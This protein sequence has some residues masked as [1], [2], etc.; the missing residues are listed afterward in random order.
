M[1][2]WCVGVLVRSSF[3]LG[4]R[5]RAKI[6]YLGMSLY[7]ANTGIKKGLRKNSRYRAN[8]F[9][10]ILPIHGLPHGVVSP[11]KEPQTLKHHKE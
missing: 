3:G 10:L 1:Y 8:A 5:G 7:Y 6:I 11:A 4:E 9:S 2:V